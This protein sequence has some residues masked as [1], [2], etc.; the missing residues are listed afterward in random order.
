[1]QFMLVSGRLARC[2]PAS[3][4]LLTWHQPQHQR[5]LH[6][7]AEL[8]TNPLRLPCSKWPSNRCLLQ[9]ALQPAGSILGQLQ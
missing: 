6:S 2:R 1:M 9:D 3:A 4:D 7:I 5:R 8:P